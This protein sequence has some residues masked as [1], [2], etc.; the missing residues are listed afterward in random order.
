MTP[1]PTLG[2]LYDALEHQ[3]KLAEVEEWD[4]LLLLKLMAEQAQEA[5][6]LRR[7]FLDSARIKLAS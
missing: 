7:M 2:Q 6:E 1:T 3:R 5:G 4:R